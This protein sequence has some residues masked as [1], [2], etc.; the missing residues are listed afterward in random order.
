MVRFRVDKDHS[1]CCME[2]GSE[3][4]GWL[5]GAQLGGCGRPEMS[6]DSG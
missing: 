3:R 6:N 4:Q 5:R 1:G 2:N